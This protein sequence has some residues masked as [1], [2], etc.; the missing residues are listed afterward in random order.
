MPIFEVEH[1]GAV[2]E[3]DA[4]D[5]Q[6]AASALTRGR[7]E[8]QPAAPPPLPVPPG[9]KPH[10]P[11][12]LER[13]L[14]YMGEWGQQM[15]D[16]A[17]APGGGPTGID[18]IDVPAG[19]ADAAFSMASSIP[20]TVIGGLVTEA[21]RA[22][23]DPNASY[24]QAVDD[25]TWAP[26]TP[27]G[28]ALLKTAGAVL[29]PAGDAMNAVFGGA[30]NLA[31]RAGASEVLQQDIR[32]VV[33]T[34][35]ETA[36]DA[37]ALRFGRRAMR[38]G[39]E[40]V[41]PTLPSPTPNGE[42]LRPFGPEVERARRLGYP[43]MPSQVKAKAQM[44]APRG[45]FGPKT[46]GT[47]LESFTTP[48]F[49][50]Q[51]TIE[52]QK[53][54]NAL[55]AQE[56]GLPAGT[57]VD[58]AT[59]QAAKAP[60]SA[61]F[62]EVARSV[63]QVMQDSEMTAAAQ[64]IGAERRNNPYLRNAPEVEAVRDRLLS[65]PMVS[66]QDALTAIREYRSDARSLFQRAANT[67][68][69]EAAQAAFA[70][71]QAADAIEGAIERQ[72]GVLDPT[73]VPRL[74]E[75]RTA[76]AKLHNVEDALVGTNIDPRVLAKLSEKYPLTG[77][78]G[79]IA[80][81]ARDFP[82][83]MRVA[84]GLDMPIQSQQ[85]ALNSLSLATRRALGHAQ[86]PRLLRDKFQ[87]RY[88][89]AD[90]NYRPTMAEQSPFPPRPTPPPDGMPFEPTPNVMPPAPGGGPG[91]QAVSLA[92]DFD[93]LPPAEAFPGDFTARTPAAME[94][95]PFDV[96]DLGLADELAG[97]LET[98]PTSRYA[99]GIDFTLDPELN[100][101]MVG[102]DPLGQAVPRAPGGDAI[103][104][105]T[106]LQ[107]PLTDTELLQLQLQAALP[108]GPDPRLGTVRPRP[109]PDD[110]LA[111]EFMLEDAPARGDVP[112]LPD[113]PASD[114]RI[115][116]GD[117]ELRRMELEPSTDGTTLTIR[118]HRNDP[119]V[120]GLGLGQQNYGEAAQ[121]AFDRGVTLNSDVSL[122]RDAWRAIKSALN[123]G[124]IRADNVPTAAIEAALE[125]GGGVAR[126]P[127]GESWIT[128][129]LPGDVE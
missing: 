63:N 38:A 65:T 29:K 47:V 83:T 100:A 55:V 56:L 10:Q 66:T 31:G 12:L 119:S 18:L 95:L 125:K 92:D 73:L 60:H 118:A 77:F 122:T 86:G 97:G 2:Y 45:Q 89:R 20:A 25:Y 57:P 7:P 48:D 80:Q 129:I 74:R 34:I 23:G 103:D 32:E 46:P 111:G 24:A 4:P 22:S 110:P 87:A 5:P 123:K 59:I 13:G 93:T 61:V 82:D 120:R 127:T 84:T 90:P 44:N 104:L 36:L 37:G 124:I 96:T 9:T 71:R 8:R 85:G 91:L 70:Y 16:V 43:L 99:S 107:P 64:R 105:G 101:R 78:L 6:T 115:V 81:V 49:S 53:V 54:T 62:D 58:A 67:G 116:I 126:N 50:T 30:A 15:R 40:A 28:Q 117:G 35:A 113:A 98:Q 52:S 76:L 69:P 72:A 88:G 51:A 14:R 121:Y 3:V 109:L 128:G 19:V 114:G 94:G 79:E 102:D 17:S 33:P 108:P 106:E 41:R 75:A 68:D 11:G 26:R 27:G 1:N 42:P 21:R 112:E 39:G